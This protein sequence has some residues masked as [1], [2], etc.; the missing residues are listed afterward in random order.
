MKDFRMSGKEPE[1]LMLEEEA[2]K[3]KPAAT[4]PRA[5]PPPQSPD[6]QPVGKEG[7]GGRTVIS[8]KGD[9]LGTVASTGR[10]GERMVAAGMITEDQLN[11]ALQEKKVTSSLLGEILV[12]LGFITEE[13]LGG[14]LAKSSGFGMF[15]PKSTILD[16]DAVALIDKA[17]AIKHHILPVSLTGDTAVIAMAD[18]YDV[19][20]MDMIRVYLPKNV[21]IKP[22]VGTSSVLSQAI[23]KAY[24]YDNSIP[25]IMKEL[26]EGRAPDLSTIAEADAFKHPV[27]RLVNALVFDAV[28]IGASDL[29]FEPEENF[30]R[31][32]Y[33]KDG[34]LFTAQIPP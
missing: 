17:L 1:F 9:G 34:V 19:V 14:F 25:A 32:R 2:P 13:T 3:P 15:D 7:R 8:S 18:P 11:V 33:R 16:S 27:V 5:A 30:V 10:M 28:K 22:L 21:S 29:H 26:E 6:K 4:M 20:A 23:E 31:L 12:D 24:G